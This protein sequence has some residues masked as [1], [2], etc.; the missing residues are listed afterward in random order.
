MSI[1]YPNSISVDRHFLMPQLIR[2]FNYFP[3]CIIF[4]LVFIQTFFVSFIYFLQNIFFVSPY[5]LNR[6][7]LNYEKNNELCIL[8]RDRKRHR[9]TKATGRILPS[10]QP[11]EFEKQFLK[12]QSWKKP[13]ENFSM[14]N[15]IKKK[16]KWNWAH[17]T[18]NL[19][20]EC[21]IRFSCITI[22]KML[23]GL[24][25]IMCFFY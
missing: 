25:Y 6:A 20:F 11:I 23:I 12:Q 9:E 16:M 3:F 24:T 4:F 10:L 19:P 22:G 13:V 17:C 15:K 8:L 5:K 21:T 14:E 1:K 7:Q 18:K 2:E